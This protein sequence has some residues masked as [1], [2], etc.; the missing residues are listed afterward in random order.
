M[1]HNEIL[2]RISE[3]ISRLGEAKLELENQ[4]ARMREECDS[5]YRI[6]KE[7]QTQIDDLTLKNQTLNISGSQNTPEHEPLRQVTRQ[8]ISEL[9]REIDDCIAMLNK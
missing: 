5:L 6:N 9:V 2:N 4:L 7:L 3:K 1:E 8:R